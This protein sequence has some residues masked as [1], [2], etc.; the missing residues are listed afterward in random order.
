MSIVLYGFLIVLIVVI[1]HSWF[2]FLLISAGDLGFFYKEQIIAYFNPPFMW[3]TFRNLGFGG[4]SFLHHG[5]YLYNLPLGFLGKYFDYGFIER[6]IWFYPILIVGVL[7]PI[8]LGRVLNLF[9]SKFAPLIAI[10][11]FLNTYFLMIIGGGQLTVVQAYITIPLALALFISVLRKTTLVRIL[12]FGLIFSL[13]VSF[14]FRVVYL[15]AVILLIYTLFSILSF[16]S[17]LEYVRLI[18][19]YIVI[20][21]SSFLITLTTQAFWI[22][23]FSTHISNPVVSLGSEITSSD[24]VRYFS[25]ATFENSFSLLHPYWPENI[26]GKVGFMK[27]EFLLLPIIAFASLFFIRR[28]EKQSKYILFFTFLGLIGA[29]LAK[30]A[31]EPF[32]DVYVWAFLH[33]P[34]FIMFRDPTKWYVLVA[35]SYSILIPFSIWK[36]YSW[37]RYFQ[38]VRAVFLIFTI[39]YLLFLLK[40]T[41][42]GEVKG[43][44]QTTTVPKEY[45]DFKNFLISQDDFSRV[46]WIPTLQRFTFYSNE[47]PAIPA[48]NFFNAYDEHGVVN[49][50][51]KSNVQRRLQEG[52]VKYVVVPSD[53]QKEIFIKDRKYD[54]TQYKKT[55]EALRKLTWL[56]EVKRFGKIVVFEIDNSKDHFWSTNPDTRVK[57]TGIDPTK[58]SVHIENAKKGN[59]LIFSESFDSQWQAEYKGNL[60]NAGSYDKLFNSFRLPQDGSYT[61]TIYYQPQKWVNI[62]ML[63]SGIAFF[64][65]CIVLLFL[66]QRKNS[67]LKL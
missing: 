11:F 13:L 7:S 45:V 38:K 49:K 62:G 65:I 19:K 35:L 47:H 61:L 58:Y 2:T 26:F 25:F 64:G 30:G 46:L 17:S 14:D 34:G 22:I 4:E 42:T 21:F 5:V 63:I 39:I 55:V 23:P 9:P 28:K 6:I 50:L 59:L 32:G 40:P 10:I 53:T 41:I 36:I 48:R 20:F 56:R 54:E 1:F 57:S 29:F 8:I 60:I 18:K 27:P 3:E 43:N 33:I 67:I 37:L 24:A 52:S 31:N 15:F 12:S 16:T 66:V 51:Q 44:L